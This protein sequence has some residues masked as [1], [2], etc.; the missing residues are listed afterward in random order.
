MSLV[1]TFAR[2]GANARGRLFGLIAPIL[3]MIAGE[4]LANEALDCLIEPDLVVEVSGSEIGVLNSVEVDE[5]DV[6]RKGDVIATLRT[7]V[8]QAVLELSRARAGSAAEVELLRSDYEFNVRKRDRMDKLR[9]QR[10]VSAQNADEVR[11]AQ[12]VARLRLKAATEKQRNVR[13]EAKRDALALARRTVRSPIDGVVVRRHKS[14][15]EYVEGDPIVQLAQLDPLRVEMVAPLTMYGQINSGMQAVVTPE[16]SI[17]GSFIATVVSIDPI[18]DVATATFGVRLSLPNPERRLPA[19]LKCTLTL[20]PEPAQPESPDAQEG[21]PEPENLSANERS[22]TP[23]PPHAETPRTN[24]ASAPETVPRHVVPE[25]PPEVVLIPSN[26]PRPTSTDASASLAEDTACSTL[27]PVKNQAEVE[28]LKSLLYARDVQST[29]RNVTR[30]SPRQQWVVLSV[31]HPS[32]TA[33]LARRLEEAGVADYQILLSGPWK[34][35]ISYGLYH[36]PQRA[37]ARVEAMQAGGFTAERVQRQKTS[38]EFWLDLTRS[39]GD[40]VLTSLLDS[41]ASRHPA[42][43]LKP[44]ICAQ[45]SSR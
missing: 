4:S 28:K 1:T 26:T 9:S 3:W 22:T 5:A 38:V 37:N 21:P 12:D 17:D 13:L 10:A 32:E 16:L 34:D 27:G 23:Q 40:P 24:L 6:V 39:I 2:Q 43:S 45:M 25:T 31:G 41:F 36:G 11:T 7:E 15:G 30:T 35:R 20:L 8:E 14:A 44:G 42:L 19:G 29:V 18:M 33:A